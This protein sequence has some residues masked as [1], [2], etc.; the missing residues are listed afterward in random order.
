MR[1]CI[2]ALV[3]MF[4]TT[5]FVQ[6]GEPSKKEMDDLLRDALEYWRAPGLAAA[7][8]LDDKV[9]YLNGHGVRQVGRND[10]VTADTL[11]A[12]GSCTKAF[13]ATAMAI[14]VDEG[15]IDWDDK[16][17]KHLPSFRLDDPLAD[18]DVRLR[19]LL[20]HRIGLARHDLLWYRAP[21][22]VR[23]SVRRMAFLER[24][25][26][27][28]STYEYNNLA[29]LAAGQAVEAVA[30][31]PWHV[32]V[33]QHL[34]EPL[35]MKDAVFTSGA[36]QKSGRAATPHGYD[37]DGKIVPIPWYNDDEQIRASGSIKASAADLTRWL[38]FQLAGGKYRGK[39]LVSAEALE[40]THT[41][42]IPMPL[43]VPGATQPSYG[44]GW[45]I[46]EYRGQA[47]H[48]HGGAVDGFRAGIVLVP[49]KK[50]GVVVLANVE[51]MGIVQAA[52]RNLL[53]LLLDLEKKNWNHYFDD[54]R[55]KSKEAE[56]ERLRKRLAGRIRGT[57]AKAL[58][59][60]AGTY[61]EPAYGT[62][63]IA[64]KGE[65]LALNWS[66][67]TIP[68]THFHYDTFV[69]PATD[70]TLPIDLR[71]APVVFEMNEDAE[72]AVLRFLDRKFSRTKRRERTN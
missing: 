51:E 9:I 4:G 54:E 1:S 7:V 23:E 20:C 68:L 34:F 27:F 3:L 5:T 22:S 59:F 28:R 42:Q 33:N 35:G 60:Y 10:P 69:T 13:T 57:K 72:I 43:G 50:L 44:L 8:V 61:T 15:K 18:H 48:L 29:Y 70:L 55:K 37:G 32:F 41:P 45:Q 65:G 11:F 58:D 64:K 25:S 53:D 31:Q 62:V 6:G 12:I 56:A 26:S 38:R 30:K 24:K 52:S 17:S 47:V 40:E 49:R 63:T 67:F 39:Q 14:L 46:T 21:W 66:S 71:V 2:V 19:D 16:V 36:A